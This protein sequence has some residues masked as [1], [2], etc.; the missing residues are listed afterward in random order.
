MNDYVLS[1]SY[2]K[3][4]G[5]CIHVVKDVLHLPLDRIVTA[6]VWA[7]P[8]IPADLPEMWEWKQ[9]ADQVIFDRW[10]IKVEHVCALKKAQKITERGGENLHT[11]TCSTNGNGQK[12]MESISQDFQSNEQDGAT[13]SNMQSMG[14]IHSE[15]LTYQDI[16]YRD[17]RDGAMIYGF[18][19]RKGNWCTSELKTRVGL[20]H[21]ATGRAQI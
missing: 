8:D 19:M 12:C 14:A 15:R 18:P 1:Y 17:R 4:S 13:G 20:L 16:F 11:Q 10:G 21:R 3:D 5:A 9:H 7:T 6:D 2:G